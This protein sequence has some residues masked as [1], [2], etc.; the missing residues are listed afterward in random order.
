MRVR[1]AA[2]ARDPKTLRPSTQDCPLS[3]GRLVPGHKHEFAGS[4]ALGLL[5]SSAV[6]PK[7]R[8]SAAD[9]RNQLHAIASNPTGWPRGA[10]AGCAPS[11][12]I[13]LRVGSKRRRG[14]TCEAASRSSDISV[15]VAATHLRSKCFLSKCFLKIRSCVQSSARTSK[16]PR[17]D[18][19]LITPA[20][21]PA[22]DRETRRMTALQCRGS[23]AS[24]TPSPRRNRRR[25]GG[26]C[27]P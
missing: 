15:D 5:Q 21:P 4:A 6:R 10:N 19:H 20:R 9:S 22:Y 12:L 26:S 16:C 24:V 23:S 3:L 27:A 11:V 25:A 7:P 2:G 14:P 8:E 17:R 13:R 18:L 1:G